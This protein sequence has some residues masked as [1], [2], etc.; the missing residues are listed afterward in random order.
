MLIARCCA[1]VGET[2]A[3]IAGRK[4]S[5]PWGEWLGEAASCGEANGMPTNC[6]A[7]QSQEHKAS[8]D[9]V[10]AAQSDGGDAVVVV[11]AGKQ[12]GRCGGL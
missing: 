11:T 10:M 8:K 9:G 6:P 5:F 2:Q 12:V 4:L 1:S 7:A 3:Q